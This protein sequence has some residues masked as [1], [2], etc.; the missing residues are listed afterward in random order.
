MYVQ[1]RPQAILFDVDG[2]LY[3]QGPVRIFMMWKLAMHVARYP[4]RG[5]RDMRL[6][7]AYRKAQE[8]LRTLP[9]AR[10]SDQLRMSCE[11]SGEEAE[12]AEACIGRWMNDEPLGAI[13]R[14]MRKDVTSFLRQARE[15]GIKL[16][17]VS[18]YPASAKLSAM[19]IL[20]HF[21]TIV[22]AQ[23]EDVG[24][25]KPAPDGLLAAAKR[26]GV[27]AEQTWYVGDRVDVD[28]EAARR[29]GM[30]CVIIGDSVPD[31]RALSQ[32]VF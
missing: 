24:R 28:G 25:F 6:L 9:D 32:L 12:V 23:Q 22:F 13:R 26:L 1:P 29:A 19:G 5:L 31:F 17:V 16:G 21:D 8:S 30:H 4:A 20:E 2:T 7:R 15:S 10:A 27:S 3:K 18:D 14:F 11:K